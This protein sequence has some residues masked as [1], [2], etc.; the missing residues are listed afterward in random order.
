M[1]TYQSVRSLTDCG[2]LCHGRRGEAVRRSEL[3]LGV[4]QE[5]SEDSTWIVWARPMHLSPGSA[6]L[7]LPEC[8]QSCCLREHTSPR[9]TNTR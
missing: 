5:I 1:N 2:E 3:K 9:R 6:N 8:G 7:S 4:S